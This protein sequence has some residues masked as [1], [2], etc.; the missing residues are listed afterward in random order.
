[1]GIAHWLLFALIMG[2]GLLIGAGI[3]EARVIVPLWVDDAPESTI[4]FHNPPMRINAGRRFWVGVTPV[5]G[6]IAVANTY[7]A[8]DSLSFNNAREW[9]LFASALATAVIVITFV[10][11]VPVLMSLSTAAQ[12]D[13]RKLVMTVKLWAVLNW[14]RALALLAAWFSAIQALYLDAVK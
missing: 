7:Y 8:Y 6:L 4:D 3:Y 14:I 2:L 5:V 13:Q 12:M 11:F 1:M 9:W 10:Y